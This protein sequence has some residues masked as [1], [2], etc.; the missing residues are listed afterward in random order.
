MKKIILIIFLCLFFQVNLVS[1]VYFFD[2][3]GVCNSSCG[4]GTETGTRYY[5]SCTTD[6][7]SGVETCS[8][9][10]LTTSVSRSC[11]GTSCSG[12]SIFY[13]GSASAI[14]LSINKSSYNPSETINVSSNLSILACANDNYAALGLTVSTNGGSSATIYNSYYHGTGGYFNTSSGTFWDGLSFTYVYSASANL[15]APSSAGSYS[16]WSNFMSGS[17]IPYTVT[18]PAPTCTASCVVG[19]WSTC[20][21]SCDG[22]TQ[23]RTISCT[24]S[25]CTTETSN[26]SRLCNDQPCCNDVSWNPPTRSYCPGYSFTQTSNCGTP[27]EATGTKNC[28]GDYCNT[29]A[30]PHLYCQSNDVYGVY[31]Y[32]NATGCSVGSC[33][34]SWI[35][36]SCGTFK[37]QECGVDECKAGDPDEE[38]EYCQD[39]DVW[40]KYTKI[41][42]GCGVGA[43][44]A[45]SSYCGQ[46]EDESCE[47]GYTCKAIDSRNAECVPK[48][49]GWTEI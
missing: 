48:S 42:R 29:S 11:L 13:K 22:G 19:S 15:T 18:A 23:V 34:G 31:N 44:Y 28:S 7:D 27:R 25:D 35:W 21:A 39:G 24:R 30:S 46:A 40:H 36:N 47:A 37:S 5:Q 45:N 49:T 9:P 2:W 16:V 12:K 17:S 33:L 26:Q 38:Y 41:L 32:W 20:S 1:A 10:I 6:K 8:S 43:C 4:K 3:S 14:T